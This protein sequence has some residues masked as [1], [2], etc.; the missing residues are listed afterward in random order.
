[1]ADPDRSA[2]GLPRQPPAGGPSQRHHGDGRRSRNASGAGLV[3]P[4]PRPGNAH[5]LRAER[6]GCGTAQR[7]AASSTG[8]ARPG[9]DV[10]AQ[11]EA[12]PADSLSRPA[13]QR[14]VP[15]RGARFRPARGTGPRYSSDAAA[16]PRPRPALLVRPGSNGGPLL[17]A[18]S[19]IQPAYRTRSRL[20]Y[21]SAAIARVGIR[22]HSHHR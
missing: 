17:T 19:F 15:Q 4:V 12:H 14:N 2:P 20:C 13:A 5:R 6:R 3:V 21:L 1:M 18:T 7:L 8:A 9:G 22:F 16:G 10:V 11:E